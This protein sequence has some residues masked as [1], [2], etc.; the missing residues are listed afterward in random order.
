MRCETE[1]LAAAQSQEATSGAS[2]LCTR[3][4]FLPGHGRLRFVALFEYPL[5]QGKL[6]GPAEHRG[7]TRLA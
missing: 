1:H 7:G 2:D 3:H 5:L 6:F 4:P